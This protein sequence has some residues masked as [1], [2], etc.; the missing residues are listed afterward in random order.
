VILATADGGQTW[1]PQPSGTKN[2][3]DGVH[4]VDAE[5]GWAVGQGGLI[6]ATADKGKHWAPQPS[7]T[8]AFLY[9]VYF[10]GPARGWAVGDGGVI[11]ATTDGGGK[12][13]PQQ[14][15]TTSRLLSVCF[16]GNRTGWA[17][18]RDGTVVATADG[19]DHW[20]PQ[21]SGTD[22]DLLSVH[23]VSA[24]T[25]WA[26]GDKGVALSTAD[27]G[28]TW[29]R[30]STVTGSD[31]R[32]VHFVNAAAGRAVGQDGCFLTATAGGPAPFV[33]EF[34][35][36]ERGDQVVLKWRAEHARPE[37]VQCTRLEFRQG[38]LGDWRE[39]EL[40]E[41]PLR[42]REGEFEVLWAPGSPRYE[43][44]GGAEIHYRVTLRDGSDTA[45]AHEI[46]R[47]FPYR[48][49]WGRQ[50]PAVRGALLGGGGVAL[51]LLA[52]LTVFLLRPLW[53]L[54]LNGFLGPF[55]AKVPWLEA[56]VSLRV[57]TLAALANYRPRVLD[58]WVA[59]HLAAAAENFGRRDT[60]REREHQAPLPVALDGAARP[61]LAAEQLRPLFARPQ[62]RLLIWGEGGAGKTSLACRVARWAMAS[63]PAERL[64]KHAMLPV[65]LE[66]DLGDGGPAALTEAVRGQL[67]ALVGERDPVPAELCE[68]LLR[69]QR[70]LV[71]VDGLSEKG[72]GAR[73]QLRPG[74][75]GFPANALVVTSRTRERLDDVPRS[76]LTPLR[77][78]GNRLSSFLEAYLTQLGQRQLFDDTE[79]FSACHRLSQI[80]GARDITALLARLYADQLVAAK[81]PGA[82]DGLPASIPALMLGALNRLNRDAAA[83]EPDNRT[84][85]RDCKLIAWECLRETF[86]PRPAPRRAVLAALA[87]AEGGEEEAGARL[88]YLE[89]RLR[90]IQ[91][92]GPGEDQ[93]RFALDPLAEYLAG[94]HVLEM[95]KGHGKHWA[96]FL[97][98]ADALPGAPES[99]KGFLLAVRDCCLAADATQVKVP[100]WAPEELGK[101]G[102]LGAPAPGGPPVA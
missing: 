20:V 70:V 53:L 55:S 33:G 62:A 31:L 11:L 61:E 60:V 10:A 101:R 96:S 52:G 21:R 1:A 49:W 5:R 19:G 15:G 84:V 16:V 14:S 29:A 12:W 87:E 22:V 46:P 44:A 95:Y 91:T 56:T 71:I 80:V 89:A 3:L 7:G 67:Q 88:T 47:A 27:G 81:G 50:P 76:E 85:Q 86:R 13:R 40:P 68:Q 77:V 28:K 4:F 35:V 2:A 17:V 30:Q 73:G 65:L 74:A 34:G 99:I 9:S 69:Q 64:A 6:L 54:Q 45:Y 83:G 8:D 58:A 92:A 43:V 51:Y 41:A 78:Q 48:R 57:L 100:D 38:A 36:A 24:T 32:G 102:G 59:Q 93:V 97:H 94:L 79:F 66:Q 18:G 82:G 42:P 90:L 39:V 25:G 23:F 37:E 72:E 63:D 98:K 26:V 75:P